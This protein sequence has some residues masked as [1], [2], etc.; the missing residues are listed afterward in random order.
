MLSRQQIGP[1]GGRIMWFP[2]YNIK[3]TENINTQWNEN[4]FIGRGEKIY[5]YVNTDRSGTLSFTLLIDH[6]SVINK[7]TRLNRSSYDNDAKKKQEYE[8]KV[9]RFFAGCGT[10]DDE[11]DNNTDQR[12]QQSLDNNQETEVKKDPVPAGDV[13]YIRI[14]VFF[15]NYY[16]GVDDNPEE[17]NRSNFVQYMLFGKGKHEANIGYEYSNMGSTLNTP[18]DRKNSKDPNK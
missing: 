16:T 2:P 11:L 15:P 1:N 13:E 14:P 7:W 6:P 5:T 4:S 17:G 10:L 9:L 18:I 3:F 8:E 12:Q